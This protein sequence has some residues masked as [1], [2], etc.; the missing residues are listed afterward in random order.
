M[1]EIQI[2]GVRFIND[3]DVEFLIRWPDNSTTWLHEDVCFYQ[4][5]ISDF[6][7]RFENLSQKVSWY[8]RV[9][10]AREYRGESQ[11]E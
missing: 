6:F 5:Q 2:I 7:K 3:I 9:F 11:T 1:P 10:E 4:K 8:R